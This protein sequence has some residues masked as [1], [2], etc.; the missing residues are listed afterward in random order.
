MK[1]SLGQNF[2]VIRYWLP[3]P[4]NLIR[5]ARSKADR[6]WTCPVDCSNTQERQLSTTQLTTVWGALKTRRERALTYAKIMTSEQLL[7]VIGSS[8]PSFSSLPLPLS[9][10]LHPVVWLESQGLVSRPQG[11][12]KLNS[13]AILNPGGACLADQHM[14]KP[15]RSKVRPVPQSFF[16]GYRL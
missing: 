15:Q 10:P 6:R 12:Q 1:I 7:V 14:P 2:P 4:D 5:A 11:P 13:I 9:L 3:Q 8:N 16:Q